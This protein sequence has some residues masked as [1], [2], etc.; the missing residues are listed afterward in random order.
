M[1][2]D[3]TETAA[4]RLTAVEHMLLLTLV[5]GVP[6]CFW[7]GAVAIGTLLFRSLTQ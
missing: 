3:E 4:P 2:A 6:A 5:F 7:T 1:I